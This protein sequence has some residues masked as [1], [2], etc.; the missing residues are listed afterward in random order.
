MHI[1]RSAGPRRGCALT[2]AK[3]LGW[4]RHRTPLEPAPRSLADLLRARGQP[5]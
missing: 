3:Q 2:P 1:A 5:E 4:T